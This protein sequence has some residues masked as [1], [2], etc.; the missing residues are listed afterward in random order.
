MAKRKHWAAI[1]LVAAM[2]CGGRPADAAVVLLTAT[3]T[4]SVSSSEQP[5][6]AP[7]QFDGSG[8]FWD[9]RS[10]GAPMAPGQAGTEALAEQTLSTVTNNNGVLQVFTQSARATSRANGGTAEAPFDV[11]AATDLRLTFS[12]TDTPAPVTLSASLIGA[13]SGNGP[14]N[15]IDFA[16]FLRLSSITTGLDV[17]NVQGDPATARPQDSVLNFTGTLPVG[18]YAFDVGASTRAQSFGLNPTARPG[19]S[20]LFNNLLLS[21][22]PEPA[23]AGLLTLA[24]PLLRRGRRAERAPAA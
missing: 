16:Y 9:S 19:T 5:A 15:L 12:V 10:V 3:R 23:A 18:T 13:I 2:A 14:T 4:L 24:V 7:V 11:R 6:V 8:L 1:L 22:V 21:V 17:L 20:A